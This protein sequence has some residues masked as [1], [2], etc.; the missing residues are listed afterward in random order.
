MLPPS[1][2]Y[3]DRQTGRKTDQLTNA[4]VFYIHVNGKAVDLYPGEKSC[5]FLPYKSM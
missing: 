2:D 1:N 5:F 4:P 3:F